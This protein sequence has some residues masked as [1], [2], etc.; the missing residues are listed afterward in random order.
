MW[1]GSQ[2]NTKAKRRGGVARGQLGASQAALKRKKRTLYMAFGS[3]T[4]IVLLVSAWSWI[5]FWDVLGVQA[6]R[7]DGLQELSPYALEAFALNETADPALFAFSRQ[8]VLTYPTQH[9]ASALLYAFPKLNSV[10]LTRSMSDH[11]VVID[12]VERLP[13]ALWCRTSDT[14]KC[15]RV[16]DTGFVYERVATTTDMLIVTGGVATEG[17]VL[18]AQVSPQYFATAQAFVDALRDHGV[19]VERVVL[20]EPDARF[21]TDAGW[22]LYV[23]LDKDI[24]ATAFN[25]D[26]ILDE[27][28]L[29][30]VLD[31]LAYIDMRFD[32][33][34]YYKFR[35]EVSIEEAQE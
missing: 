28:E 35:E 22:Y 17:E 34:V 32:E 1:Q 13:Y 14:H 12:V 11:T 4:A 24:G 27:Y 20:E 25:L 16:D 19:H 6:V 8:N 3:F 23:A 7:A 9:V 2:R 5:S 10:E 31:T 29:R 26:A 18:R 30:D 15:Y 33:R 21:V